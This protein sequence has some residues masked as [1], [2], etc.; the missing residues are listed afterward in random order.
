MVVNWSYRMADVYLCM[1]EASFAVS[2]AT[3]L[4][5][6]THIQLEPI[7]RQTLAQT[8]MERL[9]AHIREADL[10]PGET[11]PSQHRLAALLA[12]SRPVLR[13]A[14]QGLASTG[15]IEIRPG[16]GCYVREAKPT[17]DADSLFE[18]FTHETAIQVLEA[19][20]VTEVELVGLAAL[21]ATELDFQTIDR[22][23]ERLLH[24]VQ[25]GRQTS[26][27]TNDLHQD[28]AR[29][30]HNDILYR[31]IKLLSRQ[32]MVQG[33][34]VEHA[35]PDISRQEYENHRLLVEV[36][37]QGD[38]AKARAAMR[39]H[40]EVAHLWEEKV[41]QLRRHISTVSPEN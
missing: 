24:A 15:V 38:P 26:Q 6:M 12:V 4:E 34:R 20:M 37:R 33:L 35:F 39:E 30:G 18:E 28:L 13:E 11:L 29:A 21:R 14:L 41:D 2:F 5:S 25:H 23:L 3:E 1:H 40:L 36:V 10:R 16:S 32:R 9:V 27:I 22:H 19:R 7:A 31:M 8:V 17:V